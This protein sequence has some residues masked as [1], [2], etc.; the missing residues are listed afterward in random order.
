MYARLLPP[1]AGQLGELVPG[2]T[3]AAGGDPAQ[4]LLELQ[5]V[6]AGEG[7]GGWEVGWIGCVEAGMVVDQRGSG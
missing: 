6:A 7:G 3:A 2:A 5:R 1:L 4:D